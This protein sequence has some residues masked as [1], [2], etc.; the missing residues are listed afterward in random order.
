MSV[1]LGSNH[2]RLGGELVDALEVYFHPAYNPRTLAHNLAIIRLRRHIHFGRQRVPKCIALADMLGPPAPSAEVLL[3]G[4][5]VKKSSQKIS[6]EPV[7]LQ[8]KLLPVYPN[9]FCKEVYGE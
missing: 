3:L 2:S 9:V 1:R 8:S 4:W 5:G 7:F 6:Y